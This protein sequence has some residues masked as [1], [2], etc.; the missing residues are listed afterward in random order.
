MMALEVRPARP[1]DREV[2]ETFTAQIWEGH[3]YLVEAWGEWLRDPA[4]PLLVA[5]L[6]GRPVA[7]EKITLQG[8]D[9]AWLAGM[10]V[11]PAYQEKGVANAV[12]A[13]S[14]AWLEARHIP[15]A[16]LTTSSE[17]TPVHHIAARFGFRHVTTVRHLRRPLERGTPGE[18][19][20]VLKADEG[21]AAWDA[22]ASSSF[23]L[24]T[25]GLYGSGWTWMRFTRARFQRHLEQGQVLAWGDAR[26]A[27]AI[28]TYRSPRVPRYVAVLIG[29]RQA[30]LALVRSLL[31]DPELVVEDPER[32]PHLR[33]AVPGGLED[34]AWIVEQADLSSPVQWAMCLYQRD[35][36]E[37][38][39]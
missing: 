21:E 32:P 17:N 27:L 16:R 36:R 9:E 22:F 8:P 23:L 24:A 18:A 25:E 10:R 13:H 28:V 34:L 1:E 2:V 31:Y 35:G 3:D 33:L 39:R 4:G 7:V 30:G 5:L 37:L 15:I 14:M 26:D 38:P 29:E 11:D 12:V 20:R 19:P 6:D